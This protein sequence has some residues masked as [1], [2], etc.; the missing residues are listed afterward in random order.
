MLCEGFSVGEKTSM[1]QPRDSIS[2]S[3]SFLRSSYIVCFG[4]NISLP[5]KLPLA[6]PLWP[7]H[8]SSC[9][10]T[11]IKLDMALHTFCYYFYINLGSWHIT[12]TTSLNTDTINTEWLSSHCLS[13]P[14][15]L[16]YEKSFTFT[17]T[18]S[19]KFHATIKVLGKTGRR[20]R[21]TAKWCF[22]I[23]HTT[24]KW[25]WT[26]TVVGPFR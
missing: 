1:R 22:L 17:E 4:S 8:P 2:S 18:W 15:S 11:Q 6:Y 7:A 13:F 19:L 10:F 25:C 14:A 20:N 26:V 16:M 5:N 12:I 23:S 9:G 21:Q 24:V 3:V